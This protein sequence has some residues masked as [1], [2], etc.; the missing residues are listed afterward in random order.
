MRKLSNEATA[1]ADLFECAIDCPAG[2]PNYYLLKSPGVWIAG[3]DMLLA[4]GHVP[5]SA[6]PHGWTRF[7]RGAYTKPSR[8]GQHT[9]RVRQCGKFWVIERSCEVDVGMVSY[10]GIEALTFN[11]QVRLAPMP[12]W[13]RTQP[14]TMRLAEFC[15][16]VP[17]TR[18]EAVWAEAYLIDISNGG[19]A[20][21]SA[22]SRPA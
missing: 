12:I 7:C 21:L 8:D 16:P 18:V 14:A 22:L 15:D 13:A 20:T 5:G 1:E 19:V 9:L 11:F 6:R 4:A 10:R 3:A 17:P 2:M